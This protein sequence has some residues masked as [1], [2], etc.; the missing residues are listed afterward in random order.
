[1]L[2]VCMFYVGVP[3]ADKM[4]LKDRRPPVKI[5]WNLAKPYIIPGLK[6]KGLKYV[7]CP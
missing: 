4:S 7:Y 5:F 1:M 6:P 3:V 2:Y